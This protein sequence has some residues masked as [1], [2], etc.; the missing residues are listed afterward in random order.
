MSKMI[1]DG[2][3][4]LTSDGK[5]KMESKQ[6]IDP[7]VRKAFDAAMKGIE[8][9]PEQKFVYLDIAKYKILSL[10]PNPWFDYE[11]KHF[12]IDFTDKNLNDIYV[13]PSDEDRAIHFICKDA[14]ALKKLKAKLLQMVISIELLLED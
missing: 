1:F 5:L 11:K 14:K 10:V 3:V 8:T 13:V 7:R 12:A 4:E 6:S 9:N 2:Q